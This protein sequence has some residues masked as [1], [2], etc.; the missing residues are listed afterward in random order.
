MR[1]GHRQ[2]RP[3]AP[4]LDVKLLADHVCETVREGSGSASRL[5]SRGVVV[6]VNDHELKVFHGKIVGG[7]YQRTVSRRRRR[8]I[9]D[10]KA[11]MEVI[12]WELVSAGRGLK[13][14]RTNRPPALSENRIRA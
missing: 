10:L 13:F 14:T 1:I 12:G 5:V 3:K 8:F 9:A 7:A 4:K 6:W 11:E 2:L